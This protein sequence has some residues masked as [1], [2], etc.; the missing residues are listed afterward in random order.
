MR[1]AVLLLFGAAGVCAQTSWLTVIGDEG[2]PSSD[3]VQVDPVPVATEAEGISTKRVR[4][5]RS[6]QRTSWDGVPYRSYVARVR[7]D[8]QART[9]Q[10]LSIEYHAQPLWAGARTQPVDYTSGPRRMMLFVD[11]KPNPSAT[12]IRA[13][14]SRRAAPKP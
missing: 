13:A 5:N 14:C 2:D 10:Y 8:C 6:V 1:W 7:F 12:I 3:V 11:M 4:V 9:A